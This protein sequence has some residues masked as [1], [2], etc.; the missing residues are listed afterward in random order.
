[1]EWFSYFHSNFYQKPSTAPL[2]PLP[3]STTM[4]KAERRAKQAELNK[5]IWQDACVAPIC[6]F[7]SWLTSFRSL[8]KHQKIHFF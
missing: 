2:D 8:V 7:D 4:T 6:D 5:Q 1:M 3:S